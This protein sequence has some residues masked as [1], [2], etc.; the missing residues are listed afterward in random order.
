MAAGDVTHRY[1]VGGGDDAPRL[2][3]EPA[4][5]DVHLLI[6]CTSEY[7]DVRRLQLTARPALP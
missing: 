4:K 2:M 3:T 5:D 1:A 7:A 6:V